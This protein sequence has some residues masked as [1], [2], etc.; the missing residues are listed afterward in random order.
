MFIREVLMPDGWPKLYEPEPTVGNGSPTFDPSPPAVLWIMAPDRPGQRPKLR[1]AITQ[2]SGTLEE[3]LPGACGLMKSGHT[4]IIVHSG[5][6]WLSGRIRE[7]AEEL[8]WR[9]P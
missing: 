3:L 9:R 6:A 2:I 4:A 5:G 1:E 7:A 8:K